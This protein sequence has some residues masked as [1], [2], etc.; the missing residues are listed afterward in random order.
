MRMLDQHF[1]AYCDIGLGH[2][3]A[4]FLLRVRKVNV[5]VEF[6]A[7]R[8]AFRSHRLRC[9]RQRVFL[10]RRNLRRQHFHHNLSVFLEFLAPVERHIV[11][12]I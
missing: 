4:A 12:V 5:R 7:F 11:G 2:R 10:E 6:A 9:R 1:L 8:V 3:K